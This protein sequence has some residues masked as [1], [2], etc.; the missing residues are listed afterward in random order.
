MASALISVPWGIRWIS[1]ARFAG[2]F[3]WN[4][5]SLVSV[6]GMA[7]IARRA[8]TTRPSA[9][10]VTRPLCWRI[11]FTG[12]PSSTRFLP[13]ALAMRIEISCVPPSTPALLRAAGVEIAG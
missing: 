5:I 4:S 12:T 11:D 6:G 9:S 8:C 3:G 1:W 7:T 13:S 2:S 10:T